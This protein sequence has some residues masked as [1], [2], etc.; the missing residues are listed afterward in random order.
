MA[1]RADFDEEMDSYL[2][3][4]RKDSLLSNILRRQPSPKVTSEVSVESF[5]QAP[6]V[7]QVTDKSSGFF[8]FWNRLFG[9]DANPLPTEESMLGTPA[10]TADLTADFKEVARITMGI[11]KR[12]PEDQLSELKE[13]PEF[14]TFKDIL[15]KHNIIK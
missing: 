12:L 15:R 9:S 14:S 8:G 3:V 7:S 5:E 4:R 2:A 6:D 10:V 13:S 11:M 1:G